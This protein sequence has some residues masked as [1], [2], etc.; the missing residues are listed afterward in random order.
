[1]AEDLNSVNIGGRATKDA[2]LVPSGKVLRIR[3][4]S[5][6]RTKNGDQWEDAPGYFDV[7]VL[8]NRAAALAP[9]ITK[10]TSLTISGKLEW[11]EWEKDGVKRSAI[12]IIA[13]TVCLHGGPNAAEAAH[14]R[15]IP[16]VDLSMDSDIPF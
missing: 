2:E 10:G 5:T 15:E 8:G 16:K 11:R 7:S 9:Y 13:D 3:L 12:G 14:T 4:A 6:R 1:M